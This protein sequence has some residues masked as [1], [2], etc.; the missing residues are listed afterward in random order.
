MSLNTDDFERITKDL[1]GTDEDYMADEIYTKMII[2]KAMIKIIDPLERKYL[3]ISAGNLGIRG[4]EERAIHRISKDV[5]N[6]CAIALELGF[7]NP[8]RSK[9]CK[10][11]KNVKKYLSEVIEAID[12]VA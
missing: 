7:D 11:K 12:D 4:Y 10:V 9:Y 8:K 3:E 6:D 5:S 1:P 2:E